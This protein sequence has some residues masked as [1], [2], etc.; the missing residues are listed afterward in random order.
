MKQ[1]K[2]MLMTI[3]CMALAVSAAACGGKSEEAPTP[4]ET[5]ATTEAD[6]TE[7]TEDTT[8]TAATKKKEK[9][10]TTTTAA[11]TAAADGT[12]TTAAATTASAETTAAAETAAA[13]APADQPANND[14]APA[15]QP[16]NNDPAP[17]DPTPTEAPVQTVDYTAPV[18]NVDA[19][20]LSCS[21]F[22]LAI[23]ADAA[24]F[25][26]AVKPISDSGADRCGAE[27]AD[28]EYTYADFILYTFKL[29]DSDTVTGFCLTGGAASTT[30]G[31]RPG[32]SLDDLKAA[33]GEPLVD[34]DANAI[35][36]IGGR[37]L[38][39]FK[40]DGSFELT[41]E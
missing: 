20:V 14:L 40:N 12:T 24:D 8:T 26:K 21:G 27:G 39:Y 36:D 28:I 11:T 33:F 3:L 5:V 6:T 23:G 10:S 19:G 7:E 34:S 2:R 13:D 29:G 15:D 9:K 30:N 32:A 25:V 35:F 41:A 1:M 31:L 37:T 22:D 17:A 4:E 18:L 38:C 16:A